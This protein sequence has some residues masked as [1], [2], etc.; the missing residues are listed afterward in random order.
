MHNIGGYFELEQPKVA[1]WQR[2]ELH[3]LTSGRACLTAIL[4]H[5][6]PKRAYVPHYCCDSVLLPFEQL[7]IELCFYP[8]DQQFIPCK[9]PSLKTG[10]V[11]LW[12]NYFGICSDVKEQ[13]IE[14]Y[15][16]EQLI[17]DDTHNL[18]G[19]EPSR[20]YAFS[21]LRKYFGIPDG[22]L[23]CAPAA[24]IY[25]A[26]A[27]ARSIK[28]NE[29]R[30]AGFT[31]QGYEL[32]KQHEQSFDC[33]VSEMLPLSQQLLK[34]VDMLSVQLT[35]QRNF[36]YLH[37]RLGQYNQLDLPSRP[38]SPFCYPLL[39]DKAIDRAELSR[40]GLFVPAL[41]SDV[42][43]RNQ[44]VPATELHLAQHLVPLPIDHR[45]DEQQMAVLA[46]AVEQLLQT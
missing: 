34:Q 3:R 13:L 35:R 25:P 5:L 4:Q 44:D 11:F 18:F 8:I 29:L 12:I 20:H 10:D 6:N 7:G 19:F 43:T 30:A 2:P 38:V 17:I 40:K 26:P 1:M 22:A 28:H 21:S 24:Q 31:Q 23:L 37:Q 14:R 46:T 36:D 32:Y 33:T 16:P 45:Y 15:C 41:W 39:A 42:E 27:S 9:L